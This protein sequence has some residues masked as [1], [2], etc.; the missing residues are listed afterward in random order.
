LHVKGMEKQ[1]IVD[2]E[3]TGIHFTNATAKEFNI[4]Y[5]LQENNRIMKGRWG[6]RY[7]WTCWQ[8]H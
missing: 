3:A 2:Q 1:V 8:H 5:P 4:G 7:P 6:G